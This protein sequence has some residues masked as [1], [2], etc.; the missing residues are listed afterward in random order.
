MPVTTLISSQSMVPVLLQLPREMKTHV[1]IL[2][3]S[4]SVWD[5][6]DQSLIKPS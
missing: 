6:E 1:Q 2:G 5:S 4:H 3:S